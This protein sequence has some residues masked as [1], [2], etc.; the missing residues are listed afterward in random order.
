[1]LTAKGL[2]VGGLSVVCRVPT[3]TPTLG[4]RLTGRFESRFRAIFVASH[5][6]HYR[7]LEL[8]FERL[9]QWA[10]DPATLGF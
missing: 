6:C 1:M 7:L 2:N 3:L 5:G 4:E 10:Q 8:G 9:D